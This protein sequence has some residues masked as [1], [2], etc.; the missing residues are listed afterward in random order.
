MNTSAK[1]TP[2]DRRREDAIERLRQLL[3]VGTTVFT[4][5]RSMTRSEMKRE[6]DV[7]LWDSTST[8]SV[9]FSWLAGLALDYD[10]G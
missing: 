8:E 5:L 7:L 6:I 2:F 4:T 3:P 1:R 9:I 10:L